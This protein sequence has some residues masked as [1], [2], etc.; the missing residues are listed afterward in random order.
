MCSACH[1]ESYAGNVSTE[2]LD[3]WNPVNTARWLVDAV[4][5]DKRVGYDDSPAPVLEQG[6]IAFQSQRP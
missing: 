4:E 6:L 3:P 5:G 2:S 1:I